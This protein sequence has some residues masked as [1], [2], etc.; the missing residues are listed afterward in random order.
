MPRDLWYRIV[1]SQAMEQQ[2]GRKSSK[3][4]Y[5]VYLL[6]YSGSGEAFAPQSRSGS[7][8]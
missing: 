1:Y 4:S 3:K 6:D 2:L 8:Q 5:S 7:I